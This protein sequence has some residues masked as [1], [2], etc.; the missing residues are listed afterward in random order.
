MNPPADP[1]EVARGLALGGELVRRTGV[2]DPQ[3]LR[4]AAEG[5]RQRLGEDS[6]L[7]RGVVAA[8]LLAAEDLEDERRARRRRRAS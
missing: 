7:V 6:D 8:F 1:L 4:A 3:V 5:V 2:D